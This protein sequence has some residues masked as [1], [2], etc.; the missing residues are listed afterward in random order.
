MPKLRTFEIDKAGVIHVIFMGGITS[1]DRI[2]YRFNN[3]NEWSKPQTLERKGNKR[4]GN[5]LKIDGDD[6]VHVIYRV[7]KSRSN[8]LSIS[9]DPAQLCYATIKN[10]KWLINELKSD[11]GWYS[12]MAIDKDNIVHFVYICTED[13]ANKFVALS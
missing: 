1:N 10:N 11:T 7:Q 4:F 2:I 13:N 3:K 6:N 12:T 5:C 8:A 9:R